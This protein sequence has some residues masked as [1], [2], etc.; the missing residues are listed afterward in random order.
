MNDE[1]DTDALCKTNVHCYQMTID[2]LNMLRE[3][4]SELDNALDT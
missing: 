1:M 3:K 2:T 4:Y